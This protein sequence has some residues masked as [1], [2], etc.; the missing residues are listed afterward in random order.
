MLTDQAV[1]ERGTKPW[2]VLDHFPLLP[3]VVA[4]IYNDQILNLTEE[5]RKNRQAMLEQYEP[6]RASYPEDSPQRKRF[7]RVSDAAVKAHDGN[8]AEKSQELRRR[9]DASVLKDDPTDAMVVSKDGTLALD[10]VMRLVPGVRRREKGSRMIYETGIGRRFTKIVIETTENST[11]VRNHHPE[12]LVAALSLEATRFG[13]PVE[14][15]GSQA[16]MEQIE[17]IA[18]RMNIEVR[19]APAPE[20]Q[21]ESRPTEQADRG[22]VD[23]DPGVQPPTSVQPAKPEPEAAKKWCVNATSTGVKACATSLGVRT[24]V[25]AEAA[26]LT[27]NMRA[28]AYHVEDA[29]LDGLKRGSEPPAPCLIVRAGPMT[30]ALLLVPCAE[31][32]V[33]AFHEAIGRQFVR[34]DAQRDVVDPQVLEGDEAAEAQAQWEGPGAEPEQK[35]GRS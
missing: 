17:Q 22:D 25:P 3:K 12:T 9:R 2:S 5:H 20:A 11:I 29:V 32:D 21:Q 27:E 28:I 19:R 4:D 33:T 16:F 13:E 6:L 26:A 31:S 15:H 35:R 8:F 10:P 7:E 14:M 24:I 18:K 23:D 30:P 34:L 1:D